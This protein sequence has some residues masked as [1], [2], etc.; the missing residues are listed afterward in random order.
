MTHLEMHLAI[1]HPTKGN[2]FGW[3]TSWRAS[4]ADLDWVG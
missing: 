4:T 2:H 1:G 3:R